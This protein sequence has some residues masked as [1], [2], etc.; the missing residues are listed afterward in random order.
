GDESALPTKIDAQHGSPLVPKSFEKENIIHQTTRWK[1]HLVGI[2]LVVQPSSNPSPGPRQPCAD[3]VCFGP[4]RQPLLAGA[5]IS[6][7]LAFFP[8]TLVS[9]GSSEE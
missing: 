2:V 5:L 6:F 7:S 4:M 3:W 1:A 9:C 8:L